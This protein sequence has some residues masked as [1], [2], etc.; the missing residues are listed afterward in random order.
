MTPIEAVLAVWII[1]HTITQEI[2]ITARMRKPFSCQLCLS[3]WWCIIAFICV[4]GGAT[5]P[6]HPLAVW[7]ASVLLEAIYQRLYTIVI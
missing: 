6:A 7:G 3:G 1:T 5:T 2:P 4:I